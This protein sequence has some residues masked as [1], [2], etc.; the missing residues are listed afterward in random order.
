MSQLD[1]AV[2]EF[3]ARD[4]SARFVV[5]GSKIGVAILEFARGERRGA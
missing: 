1:L 2:D 3:F 5:D 4:E